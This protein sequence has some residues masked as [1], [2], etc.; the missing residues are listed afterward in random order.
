MPHYQKV[1]QQLIGLESAWAADLNTELASVLLALEQAQAA[2][3]VLE[4][5]FESLWLLGDPNPNAPF[6][7]EQ[8]VADYQNKVSKDDFDW[9][10]MVYE[11]VA[12]MPL[13]R[14]QGLLPALRALRIEAANLKVL[15]Q[16]ETIQ[17]ETEKAVAERAQQA[18]AKRLADEAEAKRK[19]EILAEAKRK[20][21]DAKRRKPFEPEMILVEGGT[22]Q[23]GRRQVT[24]TS[25]S[26]G[27]YPITQAQWKAVMG[28][29]PSH[30]KG[31]DLPVEEVSHDD[32]QEFLR[33]LNKLTVKTYSLPTEAQWE[34][35]ARGGNKSKGF[36][37]SG[38]NN[39]KD[40]GWFWENSGD[41]PLSGDRNWDKISNNNCRT[42][43]VGKKDANELGIHDMS[44][45]VW[46]W[47][48]NWHDSLDYRVLHGGGW[49]DN[50]MSCRVAVQY[51]DSPSYRYH[52]YG[53][54]VVSF[55]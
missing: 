54:R 4:Q 31:D 32:I 51:A 36:E 37:Y 47:C 50:S 30:F 45:N 29:N 48:E 17:R 10:S 23:M 9:L 55:P 6:A 5:A 27:K 49:L 25:Y 35:A 39:L 43:P 26:I 19:A 20:E 34:F 13:P 33:K 24:L 42:H 52:T 18:E 1:Y 38:S 28:H 2:E 53:F 22:F 14:F 8:W 41:K 11:K 3:R 7:P 12:Q 44:G 40:V 16:A 15:F 21:E 46:E